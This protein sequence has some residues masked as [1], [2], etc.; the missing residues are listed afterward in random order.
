[1]SS[2]MNIVA[3]NDLLLQVSSHLW[4][5]KREKRQGNGLLHFISDLH[6]VPN[7]SLGTLLPIYQ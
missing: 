4:K 7:S 3:G 2:E 5:I 1:M 6:L